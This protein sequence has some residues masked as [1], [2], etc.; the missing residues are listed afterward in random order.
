MFALAAREAGLEKATFF[1]GEWKPYGSTEFLHHNNRI[2]DIAQQS[3][4]MVLAHD[5]M[6][7]D[8]VRLGLA[9]ARRY[10]SGFVGEKFQL[11][12]SELSESGGSPST[13]DPAT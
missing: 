3:L 6:D 5:K 11:G 4:N 1:I 2:A 10:L 12:C 7:E 13:P 8:E 9:S